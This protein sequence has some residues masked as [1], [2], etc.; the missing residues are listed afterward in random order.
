MISHDA[1]LLAVYD[2]LEKQIKA[3][4]LKH[5]VDG[6]NGADGISIK[7]DQG[8]RGHDGVGHDGK[9][10]VRG[11]DGIDGTDGTD[12]VSITTATIDFDNHLVI[13]LADGTEIDAGEIQGNS[14]GD[15]YIS[16]SSGGSN[17]SEKTKAF[18]ASVDVVAGV[19]TI[20]HNLNLSDQNAFLINTM[21]NNTK[22]TFAIN[23]MNVNTVTLTSPIDRAGVK[24][25]VVGI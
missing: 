9:Q 24:I 2:K 4:Q 22:V 19:N 17:V 20:V 14:S 3:L 15:Q 5:G 12:G 6:K 16:S 11:A 10:G 23:S 1:K 25:L 7:G 8:D 18:F 21:D 13:K